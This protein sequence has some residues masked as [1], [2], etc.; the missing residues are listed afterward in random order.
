[1]NEVAATFQKYA[2]RGDWSSIARLSSLL[3]AITAAMEKTNSDNLIGADMGFCAKS[4]KEDN[5]NRDE[6]E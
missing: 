3:R 1:M 6:T 2:Q 4:A 5:K